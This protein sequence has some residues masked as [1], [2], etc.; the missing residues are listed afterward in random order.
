MAVIPST[1]ARIDRP[2][3]K[4]SAFRVGLRLRNREDGSAVDISGWT[5]RAEAA[6]SRGAAFALSVD[7]LTDGTDGRFFVHATATTMA[8]IEWAGHWTVWRDDTDTP[9]AGGTI[10]ITDQG[11]PHV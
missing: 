2:T 5:F 7:L 11:L 10:T 9:L 8:A 4:G 1:G 6:P 3:R